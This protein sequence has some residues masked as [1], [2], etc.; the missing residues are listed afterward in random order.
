V[1]ILVTGAAGF[2]GAAVT[3]V[4]LA[5]GRRVVGLDNLNDYYDPAL[6][7]ARLARLLPQAG[8]RFVQAD[9]SDRD[10]MMALAA[11]EPGVTHVLHLAA[12]AGVRR[13]L[14]DPYS[15]VT[16]NVMGHVTMLEMARRLPRLEHFV[17][18]SSSSVYG[19][20]ASLPFREGDRV[21]APSSLY[22][23]TKRS[24][25]LASQ[26]Y[27]HLY[28]LPQT[29]LRFFTVYGPWGRPDMA[30]Y[31]FARAITEGTP[32]SLYDGA[33][34]SRDFTYIDDVVAAVCAILE[35]PAS[36]AE[37]R[38][39]NIGND[40]PERVSRL[41]SLLEQALGRQADIRVTPRPSADMEMTWASLDLIR[42]LTGWSP[43]VSL[44]EG[45]GRFAAWFR[46]FHKVG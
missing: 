46:D 1:T 5:Q 12:Q 43:R 35:A 25:E 28:G 22:A 8:F 3:D 20:N 16:S 40:R 36:K 19:C 15:Y 21:D 27:A 2:V 32:L 30:Y 39:L 7:Q 34:L 44:E 6:K 42:G 4:L 31:L 29:G 38:L 45:V 17:Y 11:A 41:V 13:S 26:S 33:G 14:V 24:A 10:A 9:V 18:A 23:V 37:A